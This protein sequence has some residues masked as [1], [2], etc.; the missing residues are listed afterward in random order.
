MDKIAN[1]KYDRID[2][3]WRKS[4]SKLE[5]CKLYENFAMMETFTPD[6]GIDYVMPL[7]SNKVFDQID[8]EAATEAVEKMYTEDFKEIK[9]RISDPGRKSIPKK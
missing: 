3:I 7:I 5:E 2:K 8:F 4:P 6:T 1:R 9:A